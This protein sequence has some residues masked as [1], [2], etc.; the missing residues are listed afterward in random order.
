M[1]AENGH[2]EV[3]RFLKNEFGLTADDAR[4]NDNEALRMAAAN[5]HIDILRFLKKEFGLTADDAGADNNYALRLATF[6]AS[7]SLAL[8]SSVV[9]PKLCFKNRNTSTCPKWAALFNAL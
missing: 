2:V 8:A 9:S 5:G 3:L 1:A 4:A 6:N 7:L